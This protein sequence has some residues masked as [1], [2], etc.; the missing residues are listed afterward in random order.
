MSSTLTITKTETETDKE[1]ETERR[2]QKL[3]A[4]KDERKKKP[5]PNPLKGDSLILIKPQPLNQQ[6]RS[7]LHTLNSYSLTKSGKQFV[8]SSKELQTLTELKI[9]FEVIVQDL[10]KAGAAIART[11]DEAM[12]S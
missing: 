8:V 3:Q 7:F 6:Q 11:I 9:Q 1:K 10:E 5:T 4:L 2:M 12:N